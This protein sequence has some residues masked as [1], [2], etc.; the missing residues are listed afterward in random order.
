MKK[1]LLPFILIPI[2]LLTNCKKDNSSLSDILISKSWK[3]ALNDNN[4]STNPSDNV[5]YYV[6]QNCEKDDTF[7]FNSDGKLALNRNTD[8]CDESETQNV[9]QTYTI[10]RTKK[11][12]VIEGTKYTLAEETNSQIKYYTVIPSATGL[13]YQ[14]FLL[15]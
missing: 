5:I 1:E 11:E 14:I 13:Q 8:K 4:P 9:T 3:R 7:K 6:V 12:L 2:F 10:N 15:Q